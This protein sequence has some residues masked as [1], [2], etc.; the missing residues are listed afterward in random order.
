MV[1]Q[2]MTSTGVPGAISGSG[3]DASPMST[4]MVR[5]H[6]AQGRARLDQPNHLAKLDARGTHASK[7]VSAETS[8]PRRRL[9]CCRTV[10]RA[11]EPLLPREDV[12]AY[13]ASKRK[14]DAPLPRGSYTPPPPPPTHTHTLAALFAPASGAMPHD[15]W[16]H[17]FSNRWSN[18]KHVNPRLFLQACKHSCPTTYDNHRTHSAAPLTRNNMPD[19]G[20]KPC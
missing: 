7:P 12:I 2:M 5:F 1:P 3:C 18:T 13:A 9:V 20:C 4:R 11:G 14:E 8:R 16:Q 6:L 19:T 10:M 15:A 17:C